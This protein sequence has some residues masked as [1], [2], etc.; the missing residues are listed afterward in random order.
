MSL[1][2]P[3]CPY[4]LPVT[5]LG[6]RRPEGGAGKV[7]REGVEGTD[8]LRRGEQR[9]VMVNGETNDSRLRGIHKKARD[10]APAIPR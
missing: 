4:A 9:Q 3:R 8:L 10:T 7:C 6:R 1:E 2:C 5:L